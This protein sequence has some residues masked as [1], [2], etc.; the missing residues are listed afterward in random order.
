[1]T[2][3]SS[4][5]AAK[6]TLQKVLGRFRARKVMTVAELA[7]QMRCSPRTVH[8]RL[9]DWQAMHSYN[10]NGRYYA[11]PSVLAFDSHGLWRYRDIGFSRYGN[12]T[13]TLIGLVCHSPAGLSAAELGQLLGMEPRSFLWLFRNHPALIREKHQGRFVYFAAESL[14]YHRQRDG[15]MIMDAGARRPSDSEVIAILVETIKHPEFSIEQ[16]CRNLKQ[17]GLVVTEQAV[18]NLFAYHGL[19]VKKTARS[20]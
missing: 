10:K 3:E 4:G 7:L 8:R 17:Q 18:V 9:Q 11:L 15:R 1:M 6:A 16:L 20:G 14:L 12:L 2:K 5:M 13:E 19:D